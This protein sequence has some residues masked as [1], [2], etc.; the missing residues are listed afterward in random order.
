MDIGADLG[1]L[2][3][4]GGDA[5]MILGILLL[6]VFGLIAGFFFFYMISQKYQKVKFHIIEKGTTRNMSQ[7][8]MGNKVVPDNLIQLLLKGDKMLGEDINTFDYLVQGGKRIYYAFMVNQILVPCRITD[9]GL[10]VSEINK[11]REIAYRYVNVMKQTREQTAK[12]EPLIMALITNLPIIL[13]LVVWGLLMYILMTGVAD[14][15]IKTVELLNEVSIL[16]KGML[17]TVSS[18]APLSVYTPAL[19]EATVEIGKTIPSLF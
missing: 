3:G 9:K 19:S 13:V 7:R 11:A 12:N 4:T 16:N 5:G 8:L 1:Q 18:L 15:M 6:T 2:G 14:S 10:D 17:E